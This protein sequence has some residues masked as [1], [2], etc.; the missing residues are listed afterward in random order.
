[1]PLL[2]EILES[3][4]PL[5]D[6]EC[7]VQEDGMQTARSSTERKQK[8]LV[9]FGK[10]AGLAGMIDTWS[11]LGR[12]LLL[13]SWSTPFLNCPPSIY[14]S[15]LDDASKSVKKLGEQI[16]AD[17]LPADLEPLVVCMTGGPGGNVH[18]G[19]KEIFDLIP[20]ELVR[21][22]DLP[23]VLQQSGPQYQIYGVA[24]ERPEIYERMDGGAFD[25]A[26]FFDRPDQYTCNFAETVA[27]YSHVVMNCIY[28]D[29]RFP[30]LVTKED[31]LRLYESGNE[32]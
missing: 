6:Y 22:K 10:Y 24:P 7:I 15:T 18:S 16:G 29:H 9:A 19:V 25:R 3:K 21:V 23:E 26:N 11:V 12:R 1:M 31:I 32:R 28:W 30:R 20:H 17:G 14:H 13:K 2:Q 27:P 5:I 8:R 4:S